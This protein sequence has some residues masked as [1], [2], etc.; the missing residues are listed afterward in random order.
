MSAAVLASGARA[1]PTCA[2]C[3]ESFAPLQEQWTHA[4]GDGHDPFHKNCL[5]IWLRKYPVCPLD[6][7]PMDRSNL[8]TRTEKIFELGSDILLHFARSAYVG[9]VGVLAAAAFTPVFTVAKEEAPFFVA[10]L[11]GLA[12]ANAS[13][14]VAKKIS[15]LVF[16]EL[17]I[18]LRDA[19]KTNVAIIGTA[20]LASRINDDLSYTD[21]MSVS[22]FCSG[23]M[24]FVQG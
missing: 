22:G 2:I 4:G 24:K 20:V 18:T 13:I 16:Q 23:M 14:V 10:V 7:T 21:F 9:A 19:I 12:A 11:A 17:N 6:R 3:L 15:E 8:V 1:N 5:K